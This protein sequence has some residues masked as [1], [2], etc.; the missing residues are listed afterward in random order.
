MTKQDE[1]RRIEPSYSVIDAAIEY[2]LYVPQKK[3]DRYYTQ[4]AEHALRDSQN[5]KSGKLG[6]KMMDVLNQI[7]S[8]E[9]MN[10]LK[11]KNTSLFE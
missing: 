10:E 1:E 5:G 2:G 3:H 9:S 6:I 8:Q 4:M 11:A 7:N